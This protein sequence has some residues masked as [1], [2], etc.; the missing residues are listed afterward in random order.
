MGRILVTMK[1]MGDIARLWR[2]VGKKYEITLCGNSRFL[3]RGEIEYYVNSLPSYKQIQVKELGF[4]AS[5]RR[6][7]TKDQRVFKGGRETSDSVV[8]WKGVEK[9]KGWISKGRSI[10]INHAYWQAAQEIGYIDKRIYEEGLLKKKGIR[11][12]ALGTFAK[13]TYRWSY[14][15]RR[16]KALGITRPEYP[17]VFFNCAKK[18]EQLMERCAEISGVDFIFYWTDGIYVETKEAYMACKE[19]IRL[20]GY[21]C[22]VEELRRI[23]KTN[24]GFKTYET[25]GV[26]IYPIT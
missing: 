18:V 11:L 6:F 1:Q 23:E 5:T 26:K 10:D 12:A 22:K 16:E 20:A 15:G 24:E 3:K 9:E 7:I 14:D 19:V 13:K 21:S 4:I 8:F 2:E 25:R 17:W